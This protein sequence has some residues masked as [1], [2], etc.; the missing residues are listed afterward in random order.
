MANSWKI[1][2]FASAIFAGLTAIFGK[3]AVQSLNSNLATF[4]RTVIILILTGLI[5]T[6]NRQWVWGPSISTKALLFLTLSGCA[7]GLSWLCYYRA[8]QIGSAPQVAAIDKMSII[9]VGLFSFLFL[10][11]SLSTKD[12]IGLLLIGLGG[13][14]MSI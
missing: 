12:T 13:I 14:L 8:L 5:I 3:V 4:I 7:T 6:W 9:F 10:Q 2:A 1:Y 11:T